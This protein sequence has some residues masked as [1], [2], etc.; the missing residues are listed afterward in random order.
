M[1]NDERSL[2]EGK[3]IAGKLLP[4]NENE[5]A[6]LGDENTRTDKVGSHQRSDSIQ[7]RDVSDRYKV[8]RLSGQGGMGEVSLALDLKLNRKVAIKRIRGQSV[9]SQVAL[10]R[11]MT[12]AQA[13][14]QLNHYH[15]VNVYDFGHDQNGPYLILEYVSGGTLAEKLKSGPLSLEQSI[16]MTCQLC[17][18]LAQAHAAGIIHRDIKPANILLTPE[19]YPKLTD[20]GLARQELSD[21]GHTKTGA[22]IGTIDF[23]S[24]EQRR[25]SSQTDARSD[26]WSLGATLYQ[27][28]TG[29]SPRIIRFD[30]VPKSLQEVLG[31]AIEEEKDKRYQSAIEFRDALRGNRVAV[32]VYDF[33]EGECPGCSTKNDPTRNFCKKCANSLLALCLSCSESIRVWE[34]VC[35]HCGAKQSL[36]I[37]HRKE[38]ML[39]AQIEAEGLL[40]NYE[41]DR[42]LTLATPLRDQIDPR[43]TQLNLWAEQFISKIEAE[44]AKAYEYLSSL[45]SEASA[46]EKN[47]DYQ[48]ALDILNQ[49]H[50]KLRELLLP[51]CNETVNDYSLRI[52][53]QIRY[54][55]ERRSKMKKVNLDIDRLINECR[56]DEALNLL[57]PFINESDPRLTDIQ[58]LSNS[59]AKKVDV[60]RKKANDILSSSMNEAIAYK[61]VY[62][63][64]AALRSLD[65][66]HEN[67]RNII[68]YNEVQAIPLN[69]S[70]L[71]PLS[72]EGETVN[73]IKKRISMTLEE[74]E[75]LDTIIANNIK[76]KR[77]NGLMTSVNRL[78]ELQP[79][80]KDIHNLKS[81]L[82][83]HEAKLIR[84]RDETISGAKDQIRLY[85]YDLALQMINQIDQSMHNSE[86]LA[87]Q[88]EAITKRD[89]LEFLKKSIAEDMKSKSYADTL[90]KLNEALQLNACDKE[91]EKLK[92]PI[93]LTLSHLAM[94]FAKLIKKANSLKNV[95]QFRLAAEVLEAIPYDQMSKELKQLWESCVKLAELREVTAKRLKSQ[96][97]SRNYSELVSISDSWLAL[98]LEKRL[99]D[100]EIDELNMLSKKLL[101]ANQL[102][103]ECD[104]KEVIELLQPI[105]STADVSNG[106][107]LNAKM[108]RDIVKVLNTCVPLAELRD[109]TFET[110]HLASMNGRYCKDAII[111]CRKYNAS[112]Y[113]ESIYDK[114]FIELQNTLKRS[115]NVTQEKENEIQAISQ[116]KTNNDGWLEN[117]LEIPII[118]LLVSTVIIFNV[119]FWT[120]LCWGMFLENPLSSDGISFMV[121]ALL[122]TYPCVKIIKFF[123]Q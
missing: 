113:K 76:E 50:H 15:I 42:A 41:F 109:V 115:C 26:I 32:V 72:D 64:R 119:F 52:M 27:M 21:S 105:V 55:N 70:S 99:Y 13:L 40:I 118:G 111:A 78:L 121:V 97:E 39:A 80:R 6:S 79:A 53:N 88:K 45:M 18:G 58:K 101:K 57:K 103:E 60:H 4:A 120:I 33:N 35:D 49:V 37:A 94:E 46:F 7:I 100:K 5:S 73:S 108:W 69:D 89:R 43:L 24:P 28:A 56:F 17:D 65:Q 19:G 31:K 83:Q 29:K 62:D 110:I 1:A 48:S 20:F 84:K 3:T 77:L 102:I 44:R 14:A 11:F 8:E 123:L 16:D 114:E 96:I 61:K 106:Y 81:K 22:I 90:E 95:C 74:T 116:I 93:T 51:G 117:L 85:E 91:L 87:L 63:Y 122:L 9:D 67:M 25:D 10:R 2:S 68:L 92:V 47:F 23:M 36:L 112:I 30:T 86:I 34:E 38:E 104:F 82:Q 12:E 59:L 107:V 98:M 66:V 75:R 71:I 54:L